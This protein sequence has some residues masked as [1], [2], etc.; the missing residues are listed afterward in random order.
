LSYFHISA[1]ALTAGHV[2]V[3]TSLSDTQPIYLFASVADP[4]AYTSLSVADAHT[5]FATGDA[6]LTKIFPTNQQP[7][8]AVTHCQL[9]RA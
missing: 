3:T 5:K 6:G 9:T 1:F 8:V 4:H 2:Y 7:T